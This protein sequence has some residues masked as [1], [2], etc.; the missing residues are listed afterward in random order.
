MTKTV[1]KAALLKQIESHF[2]DRWE[3][4]R[5]DSRV[6]GRSVSGA[7]KI[8]CTQD[9]KLFLSDFAAKLD[10]TGRIIDMTLDGVHVGKFIG[11]MHEP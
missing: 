1:T 8:H 7:I 11:R 10:G 9:D 6:D 2:P 4:A 3:V 5:L